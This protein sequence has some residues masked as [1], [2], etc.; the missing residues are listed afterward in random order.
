MKYKLWLPTKDGKT[1]EV[2]LNNN[3]FIIIG[4]NG[5]GKSKL[6]AWIEG[7]DKEKVHRIGGQRSLVF[8]EYIEQKSYEQSSRQLMY[9]SDNPNVNKPQ[10]WNWDGKQYNLTTSMLDDAKY[11]FSAFLAKDTLQRHNYIK[12]CKQFEGQGRPHNP[13]PEMEIDKLIRIWRSIFPHRNI[14]VE[15]AKITAE[16]AN[17]KYPAKEM[18]DG[19]RVVLYLIAQAL[20]VPEGKVVII[21]EPELHLHR[22]IMTRLWYEIEKERRDCLFVYITHD[23]QFAAQHIGAKKLWIKSYDGHQW[24]WEFIEESQLPEQLLLDILGN[25]KPVIF[26]E[27]NK[28]SF[29]TKLYS[30]IFKDFYVIPCEGC[31]SV[32]TRTTA[33]KQTNQLH[34][35]ECYGI[36]DRDYRSEHEIQTLMKHNIYPLNVAEVENL[37]LVPEVLRIIG[38]IA[39]YN[40]EEVSQKVEEVKSFIID[41]RFKEEINEQILNAVISEIKYKLSKV[42]LS[43]KDDVKDKLNNITENIYDELYKE[44]SELFNKALIDRNYEEILKIFNKKALGKYIGTYWSIDNKQFYEWVLR[45]AATGKFADEL[46]G[47]IALYTPKADIMKAHHD[48]LNSARTSEGV[49]VNDSEA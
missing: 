42:D 25:R 23:T 29:D 15:D 28:D 38:K 22:S 43:P 24:D 17:N 41:K 3:S 18:S 14:Q 37:F 30:L 44:K 46:L 6:G 11:A 48:A 4:A 39:N 21:D 19:E 13:V 49:S 40:E 33:M 2:E 12:E 5:S 9:G 7:I 47:A 32:I 34:E 1:N 31:D 10:R 20:A 26:V 8:K 27:G 36:I 16:L 45:N 35:F